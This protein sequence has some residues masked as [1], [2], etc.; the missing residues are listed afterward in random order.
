MKWGCIVCLL[1]FSCSAYGKQKQQL[2]DPCNLQPVL[3]KS[4]ATNDNKVKITADL[5]G[6]MSAFMNPGFDG[7][8]SKTVEDTYQAIPEKDTACRVMLQEISCIVTTRRGALGNDL[9]NNLIEIVGQKNVCADG[10]LQG[11]KQTLQTN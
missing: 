5:T 11:L 7:E 2:I 8:F 6:L 9:A 10:Q 3:S 1:I 4:S